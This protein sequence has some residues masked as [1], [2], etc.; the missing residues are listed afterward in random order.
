MGTLFLEVL[1]SSLIYGQFSC[2]FQVC[3]RVNSY[4]ID[5]AMTRD[6]EV[7]PDA[8]SFKPER[9]IKNG[10]LNKEIRDPRNIIFGFGRRSVLFNSQY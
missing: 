8:G 10:A 4:C 1:S 2:V 5:R 9:F 6:E 7:Y 3:Q